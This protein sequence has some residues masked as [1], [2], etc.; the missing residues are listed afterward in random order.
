MQ[1]KTIVLAIPAFGKLSAGDMALR[2]AY[3]LKMLI[4][5]LQKD[6]DFFVE[7]RQKIFEKYGDAQKDGTF[8]F[9]EDAEKKASDELEALLDMEVT[10]EYQVL[11]IPVDEGLRLS[12]NDLNALALFIHFTE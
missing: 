5:T 4:S 10:P 7:Q 12:V 8:T 3:M 1:L 6:V 2:S 11:E 9:D